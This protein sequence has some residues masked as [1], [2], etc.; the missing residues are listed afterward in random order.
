MKIGRPRT[1]AS[2]RRADL[3]VNE[4]AELREVWKKFLFWH[5]QLIENSAA[6]SVRGV[7]IIIIFIIIVIAGIRALVSLNPHLADTQTHS[8]RSRS[9]RYTKKK[10]P[11]TH[12]N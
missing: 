11:P 4:K 8:V 6:G 2:E 9:C 1:G 12:E 3:N 10:H 7:L 5:Q